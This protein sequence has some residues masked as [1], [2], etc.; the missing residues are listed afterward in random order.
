MIAPIE[1]RFDKRTEMAQSEGRTATI[2]LSA[3]VLERATLV[4]ENNFVIVCGSE[5]IRSTKFHAVFISP[6]ISELL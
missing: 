2:E 5:E 3:K 4:E 1:W 6:R